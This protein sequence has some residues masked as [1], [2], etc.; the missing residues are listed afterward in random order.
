[1]IRKFISYLMVAVFVFLS[2]SA[3]AG[4]RDT[5]ITIKIL[6]YNLRFGELATL[7]QL[8]EFIKN[9]NPDVVTLQEVDFMTH[10]SLAP[11]QNGKNFISELAYRTGMFGAYGKTIPYSGGY[12]G[13]GILSKHPLA[14]TRRIYLPST[15]EQRA[16]LTATVEL[17]DSNFFTLACTHLDVSSAE[18]RQKEVVTI[19]SV[20]ENNPYPILLAGDF[21]AHPESTEI[22]QGMSRWLKA[23]SSD[24]TI[25]SKAP[26]SKIDYIFYYPAGNWR[27]ISSKTYND[28]LLSDHLPQ[29]AELELNL[30]NTKIQKN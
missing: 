17:P 21:N 4:N 22:S 19:N 16:L 12:Y 26:R 14:E 8:A 5:T 7:E 23:C 3:M 29:S 2:A 20:L 13:I 27:V 9:Q 28:V 15:K 11:H 10:R 30:Q 24:F 1:M 25:P 18:S 6:N